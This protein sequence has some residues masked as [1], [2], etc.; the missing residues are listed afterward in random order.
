M[1]LDDIITGVNS[2]SDTKIRLHKPHH[3]VGSLSVAT[4]NDIKNVL[5]DEGFIS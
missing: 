4:L 3:S 1:L 5:I 2:A